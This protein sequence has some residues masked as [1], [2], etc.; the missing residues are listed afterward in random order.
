MYRKIF[1]LGLS[2]EA[3]S[4]YLLLDALITAKA[5]LNMENVL[6]R[7]NATEEML[8]SSITELQMNGVIQV[9][10]N[11]FTVNPVSMWTETKNA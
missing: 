1:E 6:A 10:G 4:L 11:N 7:W 2:V 9:N 8:K 5:P 3:T